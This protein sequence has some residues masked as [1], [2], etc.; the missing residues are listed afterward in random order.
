MLKEKKSWRDKLVLQFGSAYFSG[1][2]L[3]DWFSILKENQ[4]SISPAYFVRA[5][6]ITAQAIPNTF[7]RRLESMRFGKKIAQVDVP[8]PLFVLGHYRN[9]TTHLHNLLSID[10]R[11]GFPTM[12]HGTYPHTFLSTE[13]SSAKIMSLFVPKR[14]PF[15]NV[16]LGVDVPYE[17]E[18]AM[19]TAARITPYLSLVFPKQMDRY[20][21]HLTFRTASEADIQRWRESLLYFIKKLTFKYQKPLIL[22][23]PPHT[24]RIKLLL[25]MFPDAKFVHIHRNPYDVFQSTVNL[26]KVGSEWTRLQTKPIDWVERT[27]RGYREMYEAFFEERELIPPG[28]YHEICYETLEQEPLQ[29][30]QKLY[31]ALNLP[32]FEQ[33]ESELRD[34]LNSIS[35]YKKNKFN[36]I[37]EEHKARVE[38]DWA[39]C[40]LE[41]GY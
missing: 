12:Y 39:Q 26:F 23:S 29:E 3:G 36:P 5:A 41:W 35:N 8:A 11:F 27:L 7:F 17:D 40:I 28:Q 15:D 9:G 19:A 6:S 24:C 13:K 25:E 33:T 21:R 18:I 1:I 38:K 10:S 14:R 32:S 20:E 34:Y 31:G 2:T 16:G 37:S 30:L 22:K 4:F